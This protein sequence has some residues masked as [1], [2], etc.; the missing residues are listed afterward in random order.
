MTHKHFPFINALSQQ[1]DQVTRIALEKKTL[2][3]KQKPIEGVFEI[4][5][6]S[7]KNLILM[8]I[9]SK[10]FFNINYNKWIKENV[11]NKP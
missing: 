4:D 2:D 3:L 6:M 5:E 8:K 10:E 7:V 11:P 1:F 9:N